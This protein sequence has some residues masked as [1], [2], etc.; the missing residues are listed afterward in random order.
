MDR[1]EGEDLMNE[2]IPQEVIEKKIY[3]LRGQKVMLDKE[4]ATLYGIKPIRL[5]E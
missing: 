5:R 2:L 3:L 1:D 4:L